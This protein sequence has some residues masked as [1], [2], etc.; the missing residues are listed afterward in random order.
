VSPVI[1]RLNAIQVLA[2]SAFGVAMGAWLKRKIPLLDR[3]NIPAPVVA[4]LC[5]ALFTLAVRDRWLNFEMDLVL[6]DI[7][8]VAFFT[9]VGMSASLRLVRAG[10]AQVLTFF[11]LAT[12]AA[13]LQNVLGVGLAKVFGLN[14]LLGIISGSVALTG[15]PATALAF[16]RTF[17]SLGVSGAT[18]LGI[19]SATFGITAGGLL[20]GY[21]GGGLIRRH[22]LRASSGRPGDQRAAAEAIVYAGDS[23]EAASS[24]LDEER[25]AERSPLLNNLVAVSI[26]MGLGTLLSAAIE[27]AG[28]VLPAYVGAMIAAGVL[29]NLDDRSHFLKI[30][31][32]HLDTIGNISLYLFI[33]MALLTLRLWELVHLAAPMAVI[34]AAQV[35]LIWILCNTASFRLM[36]RDYESAVMAGGFC[37]FM[38]GTTANALA[39]MDVLSKKFGPAPRAFIVV[40]L[41]GAFLIDFTNALIITVMTNLLR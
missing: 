19:A 33:V 28:V 26:A 20:G 34:L 8:M 18:T 37:G 15:G 24:A 31:Q 38:L 35:V 22:G 21:I 10:G 3:L 32:H 29:R 14:P 39:C 9:T 36:G 6:R 1:V 4:G 23:P 5:Y 11:G 17:E 7:L 27:R 25:D 40:P 41:V 16:G 13:V 2:L 12:V 30:S